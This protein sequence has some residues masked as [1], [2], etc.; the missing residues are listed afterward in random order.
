MADIFF[1]KPTEAE[2]EAAFDFFDSDKSGY[3]TE[4]ELLEAMTKFKY[5]F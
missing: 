2:L 4:D 1:K 5:I 3:I